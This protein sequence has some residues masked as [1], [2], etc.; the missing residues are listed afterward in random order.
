MATAA[1]YSFPKGALTIDLPAGANFVR[2]HRLKDHPIWFGPKP[3][4]PPNYRFDAP[5]GE[6]RTLYAAETLVG[7]FVE[8]ILRS[9][10]RVLAPAFLHDRKWSILRVA[11]PLRI[12]KL[13]DN[14]LLWHGVDASI[15][16]GNSY[17]EPQQ[18]ALALFNAFPDV[19]GIAY[20]AR[21][22]NGEI[23]YALFD[24]VEAT[25]LTVL[26][27]HEFYTNHTTADGLIK[28]HGAAWDTSPA[29]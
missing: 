13:Y 14:G 19:D 17:A 8:T 22:N 25:D 5:A 3:G 28:L 1:G 4:T 29:I 27:D 2:I 23:C 11:R 6:Y 24:R 12:A 18:L 15:C 21:H 20:R 9:N 7:A 10:R 16:A 26:E